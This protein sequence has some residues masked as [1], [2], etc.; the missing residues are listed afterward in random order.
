MPDVDD[1]LDIKPNEG[2]EYIQINENFEVCRQLLPD[3]DEKALLGELATGQSYT[4]TVGA[5]ART[6]SAPPDETATLEDAL[7]YIADLAAAVGALIT[8]LSSAGVIETA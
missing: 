8:D 5:V 4:L 1:I 7:A 6:L 2:A 3:A